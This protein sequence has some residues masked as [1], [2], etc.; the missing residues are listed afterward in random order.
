MRKAITLAELLIAVSLLGLVVLAVGTFEVAALKMYK[1]QDYRG[2]VLVDISSIIQHL[3]KRLREAIGDVADTDNI[4]IKV[5][6]QADTSSCN[7]NNCYVDI[8]ND[9]NNTPS[10]YNNDTMRR[11]AYS[12]ADYELRFYPEYDGP[13]PHPEKYSVLS[14][15]VV[16]CKFSFDTSQGV[17]KIEALKV[18]YL[19]DKAVSAR[20]PEVSIPSVNLFP[21]PHSLN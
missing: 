6:W 18:R 15:K 11:Y 8:R 10:D 19:P 2:E 7:F 3:D 16:D 4:G 12:S 14:K 9:L 20:N 5:K 21:F 17:F 1:R 13:N